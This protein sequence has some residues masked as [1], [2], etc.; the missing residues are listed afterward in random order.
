M[1]HF[2]AFRILFALMSPLPTPREIALEE[3]FNPSDLVPAVFEIH[4]RFDAGEKQVHP[5]ERRPRVTRSVL[6]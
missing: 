6:G 4:H 3:F 1:P 5:S 2:P